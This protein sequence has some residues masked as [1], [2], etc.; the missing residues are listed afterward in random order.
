MSK[1]SM[2]KDYNNR[3]ITHPALDLIVGVCGNAIVQRNGQWY[4]HHSF[5]RIID[6]MAQRVKVICYHGPIATG[7]AAEACDFELRQHN[8]IINPWGTWCNSLQALK[9]ADQLLRYYW[10]LTETCD[11]LFIRGSMPLLWTVHWLARFRNKRVVHWLTG[12]PLAVMKGKRRGYS[13]AVHAA[14]IFYAWIDQMLT[15]LAIRV[16][17]ASVLVNG[18]ELADIFKTRR[19]YA[20]VSTSIMEDDF[21]V[22]HDTCIGDTI[23]ILFVGFI[24]PE[25]GIEYLLRALPLV[26]ADRPVHA[27]IVG[28]YAQFPMEYQRLNMIIEELGIQHKVRWE[29]YASFGKELFSQIDRSDILVLPSLSEGTPRVLVESR[30]RSLPVVSTSVGG[31]PSSV[32]DG[33]DGL[34]VPPKD[35]VSLAQ[36]INRLVFDGELRRKIIKQGR[37][38]VSNY[39]VDRFVDLVLKLLRNK[40]VS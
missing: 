32:R 27:A 38:R 24:R 31:I 29:G 13:A 36:A 1:D 17:E 23:R 11:V 6:L 30:S 28:S 20:I 25:K 19:T 18:C 37:E 39:T 26:K 4:I 14:G 2:S 21:W 34:L 12:N 33:E 15:R 10:K 5:G 40:T 16:S 9:R 8:V 22:R 7:A 35:P 3:K